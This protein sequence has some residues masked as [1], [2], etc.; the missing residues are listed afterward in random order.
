M[1]ITKAQLRK[2]IREAVL[3]EAG[4]VVS[5]VKRLGGKKVARTGSRPPS[6]VRAPAEYEFPD[7]KTAASAVWAI[8]DETGRECVNSG[9]IVTV[10]P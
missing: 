5:I 2:I 9:N 4:S 1:K 8:N 7:N 3:L 6:G 10:Y